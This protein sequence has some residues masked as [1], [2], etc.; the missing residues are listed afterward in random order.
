MRGDIKIIKR[1]SLVQKDLL[2]CHA[3]NTRFLAV[4][5]FIVKCSCQ[6]IEF[7]SYDSIISTSDLEDPRPSWGEAT[8]GRLKPLKTQVHA[9]HI[10]LSV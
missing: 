9:F 7:K 4:V 8:S 6:K 5:D 1:V 2:H 3:G 10:C